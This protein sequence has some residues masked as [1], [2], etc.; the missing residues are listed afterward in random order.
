ML[1]TSK[2]NELVEKQDF[3]IHI[4]PG[5]YPEALSTYGPE[6]CGTAKGPSQ[7]TKYTN[8]KMCAIKP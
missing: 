7:E 5:T 8:D 4:F 1:L 3:L 2:P 6:R